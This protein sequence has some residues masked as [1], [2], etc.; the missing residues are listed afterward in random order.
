M[1][2]LVN[3][4]SCGHQ[5]DNWAEKCPSCGARHFNSAS[6]I[7]YLASV[8]GVLYIIFKFIWPLFSL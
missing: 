8:A 6:A 3:C 7:I 4:K 5:I 2:K 1:S